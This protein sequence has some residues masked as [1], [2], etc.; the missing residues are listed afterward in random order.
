MAGTMREKNPGV[1]EL[2][3]YLGRDRR[4][5]PIEKSRT[6]RRGKREARRARDRLAAEYEPLRD[7]PTSDM[8]LVP[9]PS[10]GA[11]MTI[12]QAI[13]AWRDNGWEDLS[14]TTTERY[15][16]IWRT[17]VFNRIGR[18]KITS[19]SPTTSSNSSDN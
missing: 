14:P 6:V 17:Y 4:G 18:R 9:A 5:R 10:W 7:L 2:R 13:R 16:Q 1:W 12:N 8:N 15:E 3:A 11:D 19:L